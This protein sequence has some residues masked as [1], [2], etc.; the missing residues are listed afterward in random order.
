MNL[1]HRVK[2]EQWRLIRIFDYKYMTQQ[3]SVNVR[4]DNSSY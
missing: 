4:D 1:Q 3:Q 2:N